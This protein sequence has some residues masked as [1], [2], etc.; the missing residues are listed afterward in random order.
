MN[1]DE[2]PQEKSA[3]YGGHQ[4]G[5]YARGIDGRLGLV[6]TCGWEAEEIVTRQAVEAFDELA[7]AALQCARAG[8]SSP[9]EYHMYRARMDA[10]LLAQATGLW[11]W[12]VRRHLRPEVFARLP[13][14]LRARYAQALG[15]AVEQLDDLPGN[16]P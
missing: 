8:E 7:A 14:R 9:L 2:V 3:A 15:M 12:R 13:Q 16:P 4:K 11:R 6:A 5:I 1:I 10:S